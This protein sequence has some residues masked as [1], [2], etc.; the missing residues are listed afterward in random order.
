MDAPRDPAEQCL[1]TPM[2][3]WGGAVLSGEWAVE[4]DFTQAAW[5][6]AE[7]LFVLAG[8]AFL[9]VH[10]VPNQGA[11]LDFFDTLASAEGQVA[12]NAAKG[13]VPARTLPDEMRSEFGPLTRANMGDLARGTAVPAYKV[14]GSSEFP[15][16]ELAELSH[17]FIL[18]GDRQPVIDFI[19]KNYAKLRTD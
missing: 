5:P 18:V 11:A 3:D 15:W 6:G 9:T 7:D 19:R 1:L 10:G 16:E 12:F 2:G 13:S 4:R 17:D 8:D 14:V